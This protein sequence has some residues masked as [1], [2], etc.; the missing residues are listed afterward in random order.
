MGAE[1]MVAEIGKFDAD[2]TGLHGVD[3]RL[4]GGLI[5]GGDDKL[6]A[7]GRAL[8][9]LP[10]RHRQRLDILVAAMADERHKIFFI[11]AFHNGL[12]VQTFLLVWNGP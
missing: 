12:W 9:L 10:N 7:A 11:R 3:L 1:G 4:R 2:G 5:G 6:G 8:H